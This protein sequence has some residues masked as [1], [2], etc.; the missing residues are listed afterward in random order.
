MMPVADQLRRY[1]RTFRRGADHA[2]LAVQEWRHGVKQVSYVPRA[3]G[4][5]GSGIVLMGGGVG[6]GYRNALPRNR[7]DVFSGAFQLWRDAGDADQAARGLLQAAEQCDVRQ[8]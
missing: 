5:P 6:L 4:E 7:A 8:A 1:I 2:R 3:R